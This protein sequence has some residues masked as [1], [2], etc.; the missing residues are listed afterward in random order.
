MIL[1]L[2]NLSET[3]WMRFDVITSDSHMGDWRNELELD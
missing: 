3:W 2:M 1:L